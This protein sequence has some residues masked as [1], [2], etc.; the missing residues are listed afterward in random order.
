MFSGKFKRADEEFC[1]TLK[2]VDGVFP[3]TLQGVDGTFSG[4]S[5]EA[6]NSKFTSTTFYDGI[7]YGLKYGGTEHKYPMITISSPGD[8]QW[9]QAGLSMNTTF[10]GTRHFC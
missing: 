10:N 3:G 9:G 7:Y 2:S 8:V 6:T 1:G 5:I 4:A